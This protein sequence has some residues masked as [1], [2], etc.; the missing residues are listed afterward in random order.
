MN[1]VKQQHI[2]T[3]SILT[4]ICTYRRLSAQRLSEC[5]VLKSVKWLLRHHLYCGIDMEINRSPVRK[6][7][8]CSLTVSRMKEDSFSQQYKTQG[9]TN[10]GRQFP[11]TNTFC[12]VVPST[13]G[14][15]VL[16]LLYATFRY[17]EFLS[18]SKSFVKFVHPWKKVCYFIS[19]FV[20][21]TVAGSMNSNLESSCLLFCK[22]PLYLL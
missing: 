7:H 13:Y 12:T 17:L 6:M 18:G 15:S 22:H 3:T 2:S 1:T 9:Y 11:R 14:L 21:D 10:P 20:F 16:N 8:V 4:T 19:A 5:T